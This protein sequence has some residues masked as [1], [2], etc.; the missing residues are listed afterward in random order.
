VA[1]TET[2]TQKLGLLFDFLAGPGIHWTIGDLMFNLFRL[3]DDAFS[4]SAHHGQYINKFLPGKCQHYP[5]MVLSA[6]AHSPYGVTAKGSTE[7]K[8]MFSLD[9]EYQDVTSIRP[10]LSAFAAQTVKKRLVQEAPENC[11]H[12]TVTKSS[13]EQNKW[14]WSDVGLTTVV[15]VKTTI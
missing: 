4:P 7:E 11:M 14:E 3:K 6:W 12:Y 10:A 13:Q 8:L 9:V 5:G 2:L 15:T 1:A